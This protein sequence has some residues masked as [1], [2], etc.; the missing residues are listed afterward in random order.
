MLKQFQKIVIQKIISEYLFI[1]V[2][3]HVHMLVKPIHTF[4]FHCTEVSLI[5]WSMYNYIYLKVLLPISGAPSV[6]NEQ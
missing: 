1:E 6:I 3:L 5:K 2:N 4:I